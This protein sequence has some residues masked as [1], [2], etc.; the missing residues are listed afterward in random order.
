MALVM[1][2]WNL[3]DAGEERKRVL[4]PKLRA[5]LEGHKEFSAG[6]RRD[7]TFDEAVYALKHQHIKVCG[8]VLYWL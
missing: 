5:R 1:N 6:R 3:I 2:A 4:P 7:S 8:L